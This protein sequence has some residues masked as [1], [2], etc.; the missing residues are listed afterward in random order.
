MPREQPRRLNPPGKHNERGEG[1]GW[2]G[3]EKEDK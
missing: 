1:E 3:K 2:T